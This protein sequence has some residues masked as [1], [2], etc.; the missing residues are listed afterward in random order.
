MYG[1]G[2]RARLR[3]LTGSV[4]PPRPAPLAF[5]RPDWTPAPGAPLR[6]EHDR[7]RRTLIVR[8]RRRAPTFPRPE[9][10]VGGALGPYPHSRGTTAGACFL[11]RS[12]PEGQASKRTGN[13]RLSLSGRSGRGGLGVGRHPPVRDVCT[14]APGWWNER[15][16][17][18][19]R[20]VVV[21]RK[22]AVRTCENF[23]KKGRL[24]S[25]GVLREVCLALDG[26]DREE[27]GRKYREKHVRGGSSV[28]T[29]SRPGTDTGPCV[30]H[31]P[32]TTTYGGK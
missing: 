11:R 15:C 3:G 2:G 32:N 25:G 16:D 18:G 13:L 14:G 21:S 23:R 28:H 4:T 29:E 10:L 31:E 6:P 26:T 22:R 30:I 9:G 1:V 27:T 20:G 8:P 17:R 12:G 5:P 19:G 7:A 24:R